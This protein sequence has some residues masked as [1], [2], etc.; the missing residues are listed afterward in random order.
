VSGQWHVIVGRLVTCLCV[1]TVT[2]DYGETVQTAPWN[3]RVG[4]KIFYKSF[5]SSPSP[6]Q[7]HI[8]WISRFFD[9]GKA[10]GAWYGPHHHLALRLRTSGA[11]SGPSWR[12]QEQLHLVRSVRVVAKSVCF[13][14]HV[15]PP[16]WLSLENFREIWYCGLL[17]RSVEEIQI[18]LKSSKISRTLHEEL[19]TF[20]SCWLH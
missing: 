8:Q 16:V 20:Y 14:T 11:I 12:G 15:R 5:R 7:P 1:R 6:T 2:G 13:F 9:G 4:Q 3:T 19:G 17:W 10:A 18:W